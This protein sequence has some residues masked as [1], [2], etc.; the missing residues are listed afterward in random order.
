MKSRLPPGSIVMV[1]TAIRLPRE[2]HDRL[3]GPGG[4]S[5]E[6]RQRVQRTFEED[7]IDPKT[8]EL[9]A[10]V[11]WLAN[12]MAGLGLLWHSD[13]RAHSALAAAIANW[14][15]INKPRMDAMVPHPALG[16]DFTPIL[17]PSGVSLPPS[18]SSAAKFEPAS[19]SP[20]P[21][22][23]SPPPSD[24]FAAKF[25]PTTVGMMLA[26]ELRNAKDRERRRNSPR[27][28]KKP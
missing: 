22:D 12:K 16:Q 11:I 24:S 6:I 9:A 28:G 8:R 14:L 7:A 5:E 17:P 4:V 21:S 27:Q 3:Q 23:V 20:W 25:D 15:E 13:G 2:M 19:T 18:D 10:D 1:Q 26:R